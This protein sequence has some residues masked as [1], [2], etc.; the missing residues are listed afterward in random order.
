MEKPEFVIST[1]NIYRSFESEINKL[2]DVGTLINMEPRL[3]E[4]AI[5]AYVKCYDF[6]IYI[7]NLDKAE[8]AFFQLPFLRGMCEDLISVSYLLT[9][10]ENEI[11]SIILCKQVREFR[12]S[13]ESQENYFRKN[14]P[15]QPIVP[16]QVVPD[17]SKYIEFY[18]NKGLKITERYLPSVQKMSKKVGLEDLYNF[19]YFATSKTVHFDIVTLM[20]MGWGEMDKEKGTI[21]PVFSYQN[22]FH[23]YYKFV[24][25]YTSKIFIEQTIKF[26]SIV[27]KNGN[28]ISK[29]ESLIQ[30][31]KLI[32]WPTIITFEQMNIP[33]PQSNTNILFR[34]MANMYK[35]GRFEEE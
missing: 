15:V 10:D 5:S 25:F 4:I 6:M 24:F 2:K 17:L 20:S 16:K 27:D 12:S 9:L 34:A 28:T 11:K 29:L 30:G 22:N 7:C 31:Y 18:K 35:E 33:K 21:N 3:E 26:R 13:L 14:N 1:D 8:N 32:D 23:H 19:L